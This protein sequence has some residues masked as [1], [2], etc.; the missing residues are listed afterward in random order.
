MENKTAWFDI[1]R[2]TLR[3]DSATQWPYRT[4]EVTGAN[5]LGTI[6]DEFDEYDWRDVVQIF[7]WSEID[8]FQWYDEHE[9][10]AEGLVRVY[11]LIRVIAEDPLE[12]DFVKLIDMQ[13]ML[14]EAA[15][16]AEAA[17]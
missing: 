10:D 8:L 4:I 3:E 11:A 14:A 16:A 6:Q 7:G 17:T 1:V 5:A 2:L 12:Y 15:E 9:K 13:Q